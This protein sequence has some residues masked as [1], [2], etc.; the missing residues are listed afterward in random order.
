MKLSRF[1]PRSLAALATW[2]RVLFVALVFW[3]S[4][5]TAQI[6]NTATGVGA[7]VN[8]TTGDYNTA[9]GVQALNRD[10]W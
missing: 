4:P 6:D 8:I 7:L 10:T 5:A 1:I 3:A 2:S 9:D